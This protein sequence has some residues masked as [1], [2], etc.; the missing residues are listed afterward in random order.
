ML[1]Y[2][3]VNNIITLF[4]QTYNDANMD[5]N[6]WDWWGGTGQTFDTNQGLQLVAVNKMVASLSKIDE[7]PWPAGKGQFFKINQPSESSSR[8][9]VASPPT[10]RRV[11]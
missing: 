6:C 8:R 2:G 11:C 1:D 7:S 4:P 9:S 3:E 10:P 5:G